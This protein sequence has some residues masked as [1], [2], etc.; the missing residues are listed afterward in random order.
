MAGEDGPKTRTD[1]KP[2]ATA[3]KKGSKAKAGSKKSEGTQARAAEAVGQD[4]TIAESVATQPKGKLPKGRGR[5]SKSQENISEQAA[6]NTVIILAMLNSGAGVSLGDEC[7][8]TD[9]EQSMIQDPLQ[10]VLERLDVQAAET[11]LS[12]E[13]VPSEV[14]SQMP[15]H[16]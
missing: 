7:R 13:L 3:K 1:R 14:R 5:P 8:M 11:L 9:A 6:Q 15:G 4:L 16:A 10:R 2:A 12:G